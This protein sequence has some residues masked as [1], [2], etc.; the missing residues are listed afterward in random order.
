MVTV[1]KCKLD[2]AYGYFDV[3]M[4]LFHIEN[5]V[6]KFSFFFYI[7]RTSRCK[8]LKSEVQEVIQN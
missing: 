8:T 1:Q 2:N 5:Y 6:P 4:P 3:I 7:S